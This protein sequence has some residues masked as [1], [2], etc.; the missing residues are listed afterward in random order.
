MKFQMKREAL[1]ELERQPNGM[2][3]PFGTVS[4]TVAQL[5]NINYSLFGTALAHSA[6]F[7]WFRVAREFVTGLE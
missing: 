5:S 7:G 1:Q 4:G 2:K 3:T 6:Q